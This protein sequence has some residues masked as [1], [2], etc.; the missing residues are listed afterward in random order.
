MPQ[1][2]SYDPRSGA[3]AGVNIQ[4]RAEGT[5]Q[6]LVVEVPAVVP[7]K[8]RNLPERARAGAAADLNLIRPDLPAL[9]GGMSGRTEEVASP[10]LTSCLGSRKRAQLRRVATALLGWRTRRWACRK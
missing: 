8:L 1:Q 3:A 10:P 9:C 7:A 5:H 4:R 2:K 6:V